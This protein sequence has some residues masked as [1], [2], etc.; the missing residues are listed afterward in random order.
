MSC[1]PSLKLAA[2]QSMTVATAVA[3]AAT[4]LAAFWE[5]GDV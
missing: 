1:P 4:T 5:N 2:H 3:T